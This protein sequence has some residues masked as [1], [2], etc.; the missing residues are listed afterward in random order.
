MGF[1]LGLGA[2]IK[3]LTAA[4]LGIQTAGQNISNVNTPGFTRQ[5]ILQSSTLPAGLS[6]LQVGTGV[7]I[8]DISRIIDDGLEHRIRLQMGLFGSAA[9]DHQRFVEVEGAFNEPDG[10]LSQMLSGFFGA[11]N[12]MQTDP[13]NRSLR[14]GVTQRGRELAD[15]LNL[16][17]SRMAELQGA[18]FEEVRGLV[19]QVNEHANAIAELNTQITTLEVNSGT[20]NDLRDTRGQHIKEIAAL[21]DT[22]VLQ[23]SGGSVDLL[24]GGHLLVSG[25]RATKLSATVTPSGLTQVVAGSATSIVEPKNG[26]IFGLLRH[27]AE[28]LPSLRNKLDDTARNLILEFNRLHTTGVPSG[29]SFRTLTSFYGAVDGDGDGTRGDELISQAGFSFDVQSGELYVSV[30]RDG[31]KNIERTRIPL[32]PRAMTVIDLASAI[33][34]INHLSASVDPS[35]RL[36][37]AA[38]SGYGFNFGSALDPTPDDF[39][40]FGGAAPSLGTSTKGPFDLSSSPFPLSFD[41]ITGTASSPVTTNVTLDITEFI[42]TSAV[43]VDELVAAINADLGSASTAEEVG[44]RLVIRSNST[45]VQ[46]QI[47]L[48]DVSGTPVTDLGL[49]TATFTGQDVGVDVTVSGTYTGSSNG[50]MVFVPDGDGEIGVTSGLTIGVYDSDGVRLATLDVGRNYSP[51]SVI[52]VA[53]GV[54][55]QFGAGPISS[56]A[57]HVFALDTIADSDT[58]DVLVALGLN[59]LFHGNNAADI[60]V[61]SSIIAN[62]SLLAAGLSD[63]SGDG[64]NLA[65]MMTLRDTAL[66]KLNSSTIEGFYTELVGDLGFETASAELTLKSQESIMT[67]L[68]RQRESISGVNIDE[69]MIDLVRF[70]QAF[71]AAARFIDTVNQ[72]SATLINMAR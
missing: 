12:E 53:E 11:I 62:P 19:N 48:V 70:Q 5:R 47:Q 40:S 30:T 33:G 27:E 50:E 41:V 52:E 63:A 34:A 67:H 54:N 20:A 15:G 1:G 13:A 21:M 7:Q 46:S 43:T 18:T 25:D 26:R 24:V 6:R 4:R 60:E 39:G 68:E 10:G 16:L 2:G 17:A 72:M 3:A 22:R 56:A 59:S 36:R 32:D 55:V 29:G 61:N 69:E 49:S 58:T 65:N 28:R 51:G 45:G 8:N 66:G 44:G 71:E 14:G 64:D 23:R 42:N 9:V 38:E 37:I 31:S 57:G 35:G